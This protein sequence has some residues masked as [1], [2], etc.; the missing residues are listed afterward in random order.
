MEVD[1]ER[2]ASGVTLPIEGVEV[3]SLL[4][5][6]QHERQAGMGV[7]PVARYHA[8]G[9]ETFKKLIEQITAS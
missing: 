1:A 4:D 5:V 3:V 2:D 8:W 6:R 9:I 7:W